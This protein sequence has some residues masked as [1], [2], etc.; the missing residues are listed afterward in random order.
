MVRRFDA[1]CRGSA[2]TRQLDGAHVEFA[3]GIATRS[4]KLRPS[5]DPDTLL[6]LLD[7]LNPDDRPGRLTPDQSHGRTESTPLCRR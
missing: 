1:F 4:A 2:N 7:V 3:R 5:T 6:R